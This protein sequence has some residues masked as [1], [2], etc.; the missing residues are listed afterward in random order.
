MAVGDLGLG[1]PTAVVGDSTQVFLFPAA[2]GASATT[3]SPS[4]LSGTA[5]TAP[6]IILLANI[7]H[8]KGDEIIA[9]STAAGASQIY[10]FDGKGNSVPG[11][12]LAV[13]ASSVPLHVLLGD[14]D[15][16]GTN[17]MEIVTLAYDKLRVFTLA[18]NTYDPDGLPWP[19]PGRDQR[20]TATYLDER[21]PWPR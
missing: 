13:E 6:L 8:V 9:Y 1:E 5:N 14:L 21:D 4:M 15:Q 17:S 3:F 19:A 10:G 20:S 7:D 16:D 11:F 18:P 12:P 2:S